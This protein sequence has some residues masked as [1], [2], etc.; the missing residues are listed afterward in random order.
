[1]SATECESQAYEMAQAAK[2]TAWQDTENI[3]R[4]GFDVDLPE[5]NM[6]IGFPVETEEAAREA[7]QPMIVKRLQQADPNYVAPPRPDPVA[8]LA[9]AIFDAATPEDASVA[10]KDWAAKYR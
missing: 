9:A 6:Q 8:E 3:E 7:V 10:M 4:V 5:L 1:M 2:V